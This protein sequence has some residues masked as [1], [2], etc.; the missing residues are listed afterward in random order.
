MPQ[1][2][3]Y[4]L[5]GNRQRDHFV[6]QLANKVCQQQLNILIQ[7]NDEAS[8]QAIDQ[9]LW[10]FHDISFLPHSVY[11]EDQD[12]DEPVLIN[13]QAASSSQR[14]V[15]MNLSDRI[16]DN[17]DQFAR[18]VEIISGNE[19]MRQAARQRY[20]DYRQLGFTLDTHTIE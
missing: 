20:R 7:T 9:R 14:D 12:N 11:N 8:A 3:F 4:I 10:T 15:L 19:E 18:I 2:D 13:W 1:V 16:P 5:E 6:C 17:V